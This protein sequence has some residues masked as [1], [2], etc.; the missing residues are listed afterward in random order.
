MES[1]RKALGAKKTRTVHGKSKLTETKKA[2]KL[3]SNAKS[4]FL[5]FFDKK[6]IHN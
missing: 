2:R 6:G 4:I 1:I 3:K 5:I